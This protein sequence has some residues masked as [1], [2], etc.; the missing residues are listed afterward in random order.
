MLSSIKASI[1]FAIAHA[2]LV[3]WLAYAFVLVVFLLILL[4]AIFIAM[5]SWWQIGFL[6]IVAGFGG[7]FYGMYEVH[8]FLSN[9]LYPVQIS[10]ISSR[11]FEYSDTLL[12]DFTLTNLSTKPLLGCDVHLSFYRPSQQ[13]WRDVLNSLR[14]F[15]VQIIST[16]SIAPSSSEQVVRTIKGFGVGEY[17]INKRVECY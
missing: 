12:V 6:L 5:R 1:L 3:Q 7:L 17:A 15:R 13:A 2:N 8:G 9:R 4:V 14:P 11:R 16:N 10:E